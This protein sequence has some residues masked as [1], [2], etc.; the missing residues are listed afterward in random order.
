MIRAFAFITQASWR[1][2][3]T[4]ELVDVFECLSAVQF[5]TFPL[6][7]SPYHHLWHSASF[8]LQIQGIQSQSPVANLIIQATLTR[9]QTFSRPDALNA[10]PLRR[11]A[12]T[13]SA[14]P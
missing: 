5:A 8:S 11:T 12:A 14:L 1:Q 10:T 9:A 13:R 4:N 7:L 2:W 3:L 6:S